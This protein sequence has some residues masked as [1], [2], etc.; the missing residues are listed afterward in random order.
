MGKKISQRYCKRTT[1]ELWSS[2]ISCARWVSPLCAPERRI[3]SDSADLLSIGFFSVHTLPNSRSYSVGD[4]GQ[5]IS[6]I[7]KLEFFLFMQL[8]LI[9]HVFRL[10]LVAVRCLSNIDVRAE[11]APQRIFCSGGG[12]R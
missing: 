10:K 6:A 7:P 4:R 2:Y 8:Y 11:K 3:N 5:E 1:K 12:V 9:L